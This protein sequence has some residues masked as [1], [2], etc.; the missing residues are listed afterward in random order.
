MTK[1]AWTFLGGLTNKATEPL[2]LEVPS[3]PV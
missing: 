1:G 3:I 2:S